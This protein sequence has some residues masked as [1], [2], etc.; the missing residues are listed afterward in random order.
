MCVHLTCPQKSD[1]A[2]VAQD[3]DDG[4]GSES[5]FQPD[6]EEASESEDA[7]DLS[8]AVES[9]NDEADANDRAASRRKGAPGLLP[10]YVQSRCASLVCFTWLVQCNLMF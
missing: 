10:G 5:E 4:D 3:D 6:S 9:E 1:A 7:S 2:A 8:A